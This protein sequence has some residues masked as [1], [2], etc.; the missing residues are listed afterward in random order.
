MLE[1]NLLQK[2]IKDL[3]LG[4]NI[5]F[6]I[7]QLAESLGRP[8]ILTNG[9]NRIMVL[10]DPAGLEIKVEEI[11]PVSPMKI[12]EEEFFNGSCKIFGQ[13]QYHVDNKTYNYQ[14]LPL[15]AAG[16]C[17]GYCIVLNSASSE[18]SALFDLLEDREKEIIN[19]TAIALLLAIKNNLVW[20]A[21]QEQFKDE[22]IRDILYNNYDSKANI[23][24]KA[25]LWHWDIEGP[26]LII[27]LE[28]EIEKLA[29]AR[30][31][32]PNSF[33]HKIPICAHIND[34]LVIIL[35]VNRLE[36]VK[37]M[38]SSLQDFIRELFNRFQFYK[39]GQPVIGV[40][41]AVAEVT[42]LHKTYQE[43]KIALELGKVF[44][45]GPVCYFEEMG[46]LKFIFTQPALEL[47]EY[48][49][50]ILGPVLKHDIETGNVLMDSLRVY[51]DCKCQITECA[52]TLFVHENTLRNRIKKIEELTGLD[53][54]RVDHMVNVY[55]A[56]RILK[57]EH[58]ETQ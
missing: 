5:S 15:Q 49:Q 20:Y 17:F 10:H 3:V 53:L 41:S 7:L 36:K 18:K 34:Q 14:Y 23:R 47:Q 19:Q 54:R 40:G 13:G 12:N 46:F 56:L 30:E 55:I 32:I 6:I 28:S 39:I 50:M 26:M 57:L 2:V 58:M 44:Q 27:V 45:Q 11:F 29:M 52:K 9:V 38:R 25:R 31:I 16:Q 43:A 22:F 8:V 48:S 24:E 37:R 21:E 35:K 1:D 33:N 42:E 51:I 4:K